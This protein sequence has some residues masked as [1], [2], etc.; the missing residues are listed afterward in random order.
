MQAAADTLTRRLRDRG[1][2]T[3]RV[4]SSFETDSAAAVQN[5]NIDG[6]GFKGKLFQVPV[7]LHAE[8]VFAGVTC[9]ADSASVALKKV[10]AVDP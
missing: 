2:P 1:Y 7:R 3:A 4:Y 8:R 9:A 5:F 6:V 10:I